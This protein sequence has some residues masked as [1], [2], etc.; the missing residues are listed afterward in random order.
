MSANNNHPHLIS[1]LAGSTA[2]LSV[3]LALFP[4]DTIK[5][6][7]Q[8]HHNNVRRSGSFHLFA[9][10]P[11]VAIGSAPGAAAFFL[12]Y[13]AVKDACKSLGVHSM[14]QSTV[15]ACVAEVVACVIRVPC[16]VIKQRT[17]NQPSHSVSTVFLQTLRNEGIRGFYRGYVSTL[18]R[19]IPF[20][21]IQYPIWEKLRYMAIE[22]N[23]KSFGSSD[24][25]D[26][27][28]AQLKAWQ[29][30]MCGCLA[31]TIAGALT[32]PLD[33]AK[34]RI[35]LAEPNSNFASGRIIYAI[36]TIFQENG[37]RGL[38]SGLIPRISLLSI[39]G[40]IFLGIYDISTRFW[41]NVL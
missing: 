2:G 30:A 34:T 18:S 31:G 35:M 22:W 20:S 13:E 32:T 28:L 4:I 25:T 40:A 14:V 12:T 24:V 17:Q 1:L 26:L 6:R 23:R 3:D 10:W 21:V 15:S 38:F 16:E 37:I 33:V 9:G 7:L 11:A 29:S 5:T 8:S 41:T 27:T 19:E 36:R 39:G